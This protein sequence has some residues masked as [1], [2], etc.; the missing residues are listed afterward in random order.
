VNIGR[1]IAKRKNAL[2]SNRTRRRWG[3][4]KKVSAAWTFLAFLYI[5]P[6]SKAKDLKLKHLKGWMIFSPYSENGV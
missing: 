6:F 3:S 2:G 4:Q 1:N 5:R